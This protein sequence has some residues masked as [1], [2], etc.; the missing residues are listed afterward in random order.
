MGEYDVRTYNLF[1]S[2]SWAHSDSYEKLIGLLEKRNYFDFKDYSVPKDD[3]IHTNGTDKQLNQ[4]ILQKMRPCSAVLILAGVYASYSKWIAKEIDIA[5]QLE[6]PVIAIE[7]WASE[8]TSQVV[9]DNAER[10]VGWNTNSVVDA[11]R[12]VA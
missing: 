5:N 2:H 10:I 11:I 12:A 8:K 3:P 7:P 4:A 1:V 9:K 6:K